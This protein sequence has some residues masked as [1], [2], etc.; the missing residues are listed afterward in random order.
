MSAHCEESRL[1]IGKLADVMS[2]VALRWK[3][4]QWVVKEVLVELGSDPTLAEINKIT[5][6]VINTSLS[7]NNVA[8][9]VH[10]TKA[11]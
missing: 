11:S 6:H 9:R 4:P 10:E 2:Q 1:L 8:S 5:K 7:F 3:V